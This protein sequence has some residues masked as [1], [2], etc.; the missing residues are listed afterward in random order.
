M[1]GYKKNENVVTSDAPVT[2]LVARK[3]AKILKRVGFLD[4]ERVI[5]ILS[6]RESY[7]EF[8]IAR[9]TDDVTKMR[10]SAFLDDEDNTLSAITLTTHSGSRYPVK[11][12]ISADEK[13]ATL[14]ER[15]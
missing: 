4:T 15:S 2:P 14:L 1:F 13:L 7:G 5:S 3:I 6:D 10:F 9:Y 12:V 8:L 11:N